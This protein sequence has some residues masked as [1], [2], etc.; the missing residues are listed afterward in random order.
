MAA[1][2]TDVSGTN[3]PGIIAVCAIFSALSILFVGARLARCWRLRSFAIEDALVTLALVNGMPGWIR[4]GSYADSLSLVHHARRRWHLLRRS[5][6]WLRQTRK[7]TDS[8]GLAQ[9]ISAGMDLG[10]RRVLG[11]SDS[12]VERRLHVAQAWLRT[13]VP[14]HSVLQYAPLLRHQLVVFD[15]AAERL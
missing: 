7:H 3:A 14:S 12:Q 8:A 4:R 5:S 15:H 13:S 2:V 11:I 9:D 1:E 10:S 6:I